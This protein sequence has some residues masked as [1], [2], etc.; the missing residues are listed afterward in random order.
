MLLV[1]EAQYDAIVAVHG[2]SETQ[3]RSIH[4]TIYRRESLNYGVPHAW[5][6]F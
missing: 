1:F 4:R 5:P 6:I 2:F 3:L